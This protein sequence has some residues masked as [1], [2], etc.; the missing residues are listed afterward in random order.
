MFESSSAESADDQIA[1]A[2]DGLAGAELAAA[3]AE[4]VGVLGSR[5][6]LSAFGTVEAVIGFERVARWA[7][8]QKLAL[9]GRL[10]DERGVQE[11]SGALLLGT[12]VSLALG[13]G[14]HTADA[15]VAD[16]VAMRTRVPMVLSALQAG[17]VCE[18]GAHAI[19]TETAVL[20]APGAARVAAAVL[21]RPGLRTVPRLRAATKAAVLRADPATAEMREARAV[22]GRFVR[23]Y[24]RIEDGMVG[25]H[26]WLPAADSLRMWDRL[27]ALG[28]ASKVPG[29]HRG[30]EARRADVLCDL[31]L[32]RPVSTAAGD[33]VD[34]ANPSARRVWRT[35]LVVEASTLQGRDEHPG[36]APSWGPLTAATA[37]RLAAGQGAVDRPAQP[38]TRGQQAAEG[39]S[40]SSAQWRRILTDPLTGMVTDYGTTRYRPPA[41]LADLVRARDGRCYEPSCTVTAWRADLDHIRPSP[42]GPSPSPGA[43]GATSAANLAPACRR[44]HRTK[45]APGWAVRAGPDRGAFTWTTPTGHTYTRHAEAPLPWHG[46]SALEPPGPTTALHHTH[47]LPAADAD[48]RRLDDPL[49]AP[50]PACCPTPSWDVSA[51]D[52][53]WDSGVDVERDIERV[54]SRL[55]VTYLSL[56]QGERYEMDIALPPPF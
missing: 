1:A 3:L 38:A 5:N 12:E 8:A 46:H 53:S 45:Q 31:L 10:G 42:A 18:R 24:H 4:V 56:C 21:A 37:R 13:V 51:D 44:H 39:V 23:A 7:Q 22:R 32:S 35:D 41:E 36:H 28:E 2:V 6:G 55:D 34:T 48:D 49:H 14:R 19:V 16:A 20:D 11:T 27:R 33:V 25:W 30:A 47:P 9:L 15:L 54:L 52:A 17:Q 40:E 43:D 50:P 29:D 26:A